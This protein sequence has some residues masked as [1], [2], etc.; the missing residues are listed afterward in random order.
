MDFLLFCSLAGEQNG[1]ENDDSYH[2]LR[3]SYAFSYGHEAPLGEHRIGS[4]GTSACIA[5]SSA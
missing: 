1:K 2:M 5:G 3:K 4:T